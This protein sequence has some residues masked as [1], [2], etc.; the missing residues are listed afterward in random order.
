[1][2]VGSPKFRWYELRKLFLE[3]DCTSQL[4]C[5]SYVIIPAASPRRQ[6]PCHTVHP[7]RQ[8]GPATPIPNATP[9]SSHLLPFPSP[10]QTYYPHC[11]VSTHGRPRTRHPP[12]S[13][14]G[15][16]SRSRSEASASPAR[17]V[18]GLTASRPA[19]PPAQ[20]YKPPLQPPSPAAAAS[21]P[22]S[23]CNC[24]PAGP[25]NREPTRSPLHSFTHCS[26]AAA[27][28]WP[29]PLTYS[30]I[31]PPPTNQPTNTPAPFNRT[32]TPRSSP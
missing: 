10:P 26:R 21:L 28:A 3:L 23:C 29:S 18:G 20:L 8:A 17:V 5:E 9:P 25:R 24:R 15:S 27:P 7:P 19:P 2:E 16:R 12:R 11:A 13:R 6:F 32:D 4:C 22:S 14:S 1:M 30:S 31:R